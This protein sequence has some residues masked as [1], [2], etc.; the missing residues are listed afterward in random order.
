MYVRQLINVKFN[1]NEFIIN[2]FHK[3][4]VGSNCS[5]FWGLLTVMLME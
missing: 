1:V 3:Q 5:M 2:K 4:D